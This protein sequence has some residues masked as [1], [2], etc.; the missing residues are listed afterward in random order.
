MISQQQ[1]SELSRS[2]SSLRPHNGLALRE[3]IL[4]FFWL[5]AGLYLS[6]QPGLGWPLGQVLLGIGLWRAFVIQHACGHHAFFK[7]P[8]LNNL[9]GISQSLFCFIP[10]FP[11]KYIHQAH[12]TW[13]GWKDLDPTTMELDKALPQWKKKLVNFCWRYWIPLLSVHYIISLFFSFKRRQFLESEALAILSML[14]VLVPHLILAYTMPG[15]Y[16]KSFGLAAWIYLNLGDISLLT[17][18]VHLPLDH[19]GGDIVRPKLLREQDHYSHTVQFP[20]WVERWITL[21][22]NQHSLHHLFPRM[23]YYYSA[24][25]PFAGE[26]TH[27]WSEWIS[28]SK[29]MAAMD[30]LYPD[31]DSPLLHPE[32]D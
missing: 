13:T 27:H 18:H 29:K 3:L 26:H 10:Y 31:V 5:A 6:H 25:I 15:F 14:I 21:G 8:A 32:G 23:P 22:F 9:I 11:W 24:K 16:M 4:Q 30:L 20:S 19:S 17:Q 28:K 2:A 1:Y 12:H 7:G